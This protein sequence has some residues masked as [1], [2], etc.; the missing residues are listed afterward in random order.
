MNGKIQGKT[1]VPTLYC[2]QGSILLAAHTSIAL[3]IV[4]S[5]A[6]CKGRIAH[7]S[8]CFVDDTDGQVSVKHNS[9]SP[10]VETVGKLQN[11]SQKWSNLINLTGHFLALHKPNRR[12]VAW[13]TESETIIEDRKGAFAVMDYKSPDLPNPGLGFKHCPDDNQAHQYKDILG[14]VQ[15]IC[16]V[17]SAE[18]LT[19]REAK[20]ALEQRLVPKMAY[21]L[22]L[23]SL[24][25]HAAIWRAFFPMMRFNRNFPSAV[26]YGPMEHGGMEFP[27]A[28]S[29][30]DQL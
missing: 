3:G 23:S 15:E 26:A 2:Q 12:M 25:K 21:P 4:L 8:V 22:H 20:Q 9:A 11:S 29:L 30:Q 13:S 6:T 27:D 19:E 14:E 10:V 24:T 18:H 28:Y 5:S 16:S 7:H 17:V 1:D